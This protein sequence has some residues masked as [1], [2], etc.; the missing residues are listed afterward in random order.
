V[1]VD[2]H[3]QNPHSKAAKSATLEWGTLEKW[4]PRAS[5]TRKEREKESV[6]V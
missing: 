5:L 1:T 6:A 3:G 2:H 4:A